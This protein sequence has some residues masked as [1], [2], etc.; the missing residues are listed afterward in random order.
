MQTKYSTFVKALT[1]KA[2]IVLS[3]ARLPRQ[4]VIHLMQHYVRLTGRSPPIIFARTD[5]PMNAL[6][7]CRSQFSHKETL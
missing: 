5:R 4:R 6:Q 7:L 1:S 2:N 3:Y